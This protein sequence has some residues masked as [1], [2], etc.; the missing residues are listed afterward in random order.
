MRMG[1]TVLALLFSTI[2][3]RSCARA[4]SFRHPRCRTFQETSPMIRFGLIACAYLFA[5][6]QPLRGASA[7]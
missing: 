5:A 4:F 1:L 6:H 3:A 2:S 7:R